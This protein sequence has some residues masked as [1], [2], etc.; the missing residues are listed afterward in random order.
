MINQ[1]KRCGAAFALVI[2]AISSSGC[3]L[4]PNDGDRVANRD[5]YIPF[6][7]ATA[8]TDGRVTI[9]AKN[10]TSGT[11]QEIGSVDTYLGP[12]EWE[13]YDWY[14][15]SN[16]LQIPRSCWKT[17]FAGN[18]V[19]RVYFKAEIRARAATGNVR[20]FRRGFYDWFSDGAYWDSG[21]RNRRTIGEVEEFYQGNV[22]TIYTN[23]QNL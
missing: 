1:M 8:G 9:E 22:I 3:M 14:I 6:R 4:S 23:V 10:Q 16:S 21:Y 19:D 12:I 15:G 2:I 18:T 5:T 20:T 7:V 11:W 13:G 17:L